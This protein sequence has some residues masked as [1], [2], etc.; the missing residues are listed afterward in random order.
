MAEKYWCD[1]PSIKAGSIGIKPGGGRVGPEREPLG[2]SSEQADDDTGRL[3]R[4]C[5][6]PGF[7]GLHGEKAGENTWEKTG[8]MREVKRKVDPVGAVKGEPMK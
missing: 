8:G 2:S 7:I 6:P 1:R 3:S 4:Y 5:N